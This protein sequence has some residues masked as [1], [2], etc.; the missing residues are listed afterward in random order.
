MCYNKKKW[1]SHHHYRDIRQYNDL[2]TEFFV[3]KEQ[4]KTFN[5]IEMGI[6]FRHYTLITITCVHSFA[7]PVVTED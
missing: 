2:L 4:P 7:H 5:Y 3:I 6:L 1:L